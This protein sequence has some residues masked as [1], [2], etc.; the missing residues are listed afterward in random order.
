MLLTNANALASAPVISY[1]FML[2]GAVEVLIT[3]SVKILSRIVPTFCLSNDKSLAEYC[4]L[5]ID[6]YFSETASWI[7]NYH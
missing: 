2:N 6:Q 7:C 1:L 3:K 4:G 5:T